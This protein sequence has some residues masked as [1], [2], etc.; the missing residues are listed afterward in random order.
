M[1]IFRFFVSGMAELG[2]EKL[3]SFGG[4]LALLVRH[5]SP[6]ALGISDLDDIGLRNAPGLGKV[7]ENSGN[8]KHLFSVKY[9]ARQV[10]SGR[11]S[12]S[13]RSVHSST[14]AR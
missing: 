6:V 9:T 14:R 12:L 3:Y 4:N 8:V 10:G 11:A 1:A 7:I 5:H 13:L 2:V